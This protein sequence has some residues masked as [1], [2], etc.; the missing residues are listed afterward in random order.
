MA[1]AGLLEVA[2]PGPGV[3]RR[4]RRAGARQRRRPDPG[5]QPAAPRRG[6]GPGRAGRLRQRRSGKASGLDP[7]RLSLL[8]RRPRPAGRHRPGQP[9]RLRQPRRRAVRGGT[10][11][12]PARWPWPSPRP[13]ATDRSR[14]GPSSI[15]EVGLLGELRAVTGLERRL[16][17][18][19]RLGFTRGDRAAARPRGRPAR[20]PRVCDVVA[21]ATLRDAVEA[22]ARLRGRPPWRRRPGDARLTARPGR[23]RPGDAGTVRR[24]SR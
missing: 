9:R 12:G 15:G 6:P 3:P 13:C 16:R 17:E 11:P 10:R 18:A 23:S 7:N 14:P 4:P 21:V 2:D 1:E 22:G 19:A 8:D 5:G 20:R 24:G